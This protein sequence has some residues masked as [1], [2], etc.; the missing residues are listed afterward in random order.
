M[1][2]DFG[3]DLIESL[4]QA[5]AHAKGQ[6]KVAQ[7]HMVHVP[8]VRTLRERL[9]MSQQTFASTYRIPLATLK[10]WEQG[11]RQPD[12]TAVAYLSVIEK[13]PRETRAALAA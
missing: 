11:R 8:D 12:A 1:G 10:G 2:S 9:K 6:V 3:T 13:M 5:V 4:N 7:V